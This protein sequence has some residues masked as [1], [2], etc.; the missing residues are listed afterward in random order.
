MAPIDRYQSSRE[1]ILATIRLRGPCLP[2]QLAR[3]IDMNTL[4]TSAFLSELYADQKLKKSNLTIGSSALYFILGQEAQLE[5]FVHYLNQREKEAF[6]ILKQEKILDDTA[7]TP[8]IRVALRAIKDFAIPITIK[9]NTEEKLFWKY[10]LLN[11]TEAHELI[12]QKTKSQQLPSEQKQMK[13]DA[14]QTPLTISQETNEED[15]KTGQ[16][17]KAKKKGRISQKGEKESK[18]EFSKRVRDYL[19]AKEIEILEISLEKKKELLARVRIDT[20]FGK[21]EFFLSVYDKKKLTDKDLTVAVQK[22]SGMR[23]PSL[24]IATGDLNAAGKEYLKVWKNL[25][26]FERLQI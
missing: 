21:Q 6:S 5:Q 10:F 8:V 26:R 22:G 14:V 2:V 3:E 13:T 15:K 24:V 9:Q 20:L 25:L 23:M 7:Q 18:T 19:Q 11:D 1:R 4:F 16:E 17:E 12:E